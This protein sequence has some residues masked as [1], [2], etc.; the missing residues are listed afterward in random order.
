MKPR[1]SPKINFWAG[2]SRRVATKVVIFRGT[3]T[4]TH[5]VDILETGIHP[6]LARYFPVEHRFQQDYDP[7]Y[8]SRFA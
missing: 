2:V 7:K 1:H 3:M 6:F 8:N 4:A 5:Y